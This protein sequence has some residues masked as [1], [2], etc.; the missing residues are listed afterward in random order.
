M[1]RPKTRQWVVKASKRRRRKYLIK[2]LLFFQNFFQNAAI[3][4]T[5]VVLG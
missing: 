5:N 2:I 4:V 3:T 1:R